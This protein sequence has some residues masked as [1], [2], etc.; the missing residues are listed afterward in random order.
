MSVVDI[1]LE[2][3]GGLGVHLGD[4]LPSERK[5]AELC[6][7]SRSSVR[8]ALKELQSKRVL[9]T[10]PGSGYFLSSD[11]ALHQALSGV[12]AEWTINRVR[13]VFEARTFVAARVTQLGSGNMTAS[14]LQELEDCLVDLGKAVVNIDTRAME[15][16]HNR[17]I[18]IIHENCLNP[19]YLRML[20]EVQLPSHYVVSI[21]QVVTGDER[22]DYFSEHVNL[23]H[24]VK[25]KEH[26]LARDVY[27]QI[28]EKILSLFNK[29]TD[30]V[31]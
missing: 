31:F 14:S 15:I 22:N 10:R 5:L 7:I 28:C 19:E 6:D 11:F 9:A 4:R 8:N 23:F 29:Y 26:S 30:V 12:D 20:N 3:I 27:V 2:E 18:N 21:L 25:N 24:A 16:F 1:V 13:Q 17:F